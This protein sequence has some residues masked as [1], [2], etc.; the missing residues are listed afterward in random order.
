MRTLA[1]RENGG[2]K[3]VLDDF[4]II[5]VELVTIAIFIVLK[6]EAEQDFKISNGVRVVKGIIVRQIT[7]QIPAK[8]KR[9]NFVVAR[10][11]VVHSLFHAKA[12]ME[13]AV[14]NK[15]KNGGYYL[16]YYGKKIIFTC[17]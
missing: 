3:T 7:V 10:K 5:E 1:V 15:S 6:T 16:R 17:S 13:A 14:V 11:V 4:S 2:K 8:E 12:E 9:V